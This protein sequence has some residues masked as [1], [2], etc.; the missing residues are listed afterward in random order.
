[1]QAARLFLSVVKMIYPNISEEVM[2]R[3]ILL[4][5][6]RERAVAREQDFSHIDVTTKVR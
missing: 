5:V 4:D 6:I 2:A 1:M 3:G